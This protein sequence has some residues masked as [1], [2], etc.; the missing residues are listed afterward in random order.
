MKTTMVARG[1]GCSPLEGGLCCCL[2]CRGG[3]SA[4]S[5]LPHPRRRSQREDAR[6]AERLRRGRG[7]SRGALCSG[8]RGQ[9]QL[10]PPRSSVPEEESRRA[11]PLLWPSRPPP[12]RSL[13]GRILPGPWAEPHG[14][15]EAL[16]SSGAVPMVPQ[17]AAALQTSTLASE[18]VWPAGKSWEAFSPC[19]WDCPAAGMESQGGAGAGGSGCPPL[20]PQRIPPPRPAA[21]VQDA[22]GIPLHRQKGPEH[23]PGPAWLLAGCPNVWSQAQIW[24]RAP[25]TARTPQGQKRAKG[26][27][28]AGQLQRWG[29]LEDFLPCISYVPSASSAPQLLHDPAPSLPPAQA[30]WGPLPTRSPR[31]CRRLRA[32][33]SQ[34]FSQREG[35]RDII[36]T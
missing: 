3:P 17:G 34:L 14:A 15:P 35:R 18:P 1:R 23:V 12:A 7:W 16:R 33:A 2:L 26:T 32:D 28:P 6:P 5:P 27:S 8:R 4:P 19:P 10:L 22:P 24:L 13:Q 36:R 25:G 11:G 31:R 29:G 30:G 21:M 20:S 9:P